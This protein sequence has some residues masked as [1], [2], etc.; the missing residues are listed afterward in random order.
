MARR[1]RLPKASQNDHGESSAAPPGYPIGRGRPP[2]HSRFPPGTSGNPK[3]R[4]KGARNKRTIVEQALNERIKVR[5]NGRMRSLRKFEVLV[6][7]ML[8]KEL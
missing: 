3:G 5:E 8:N 1:P 6:M 7:T 2:V 4:R